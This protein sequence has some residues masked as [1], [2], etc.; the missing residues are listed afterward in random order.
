VGMLEEALAA[1]FW[2]ARASGRVVAHHEPRPRASP[3][4]GKP[5]K[6]TATS[7]KT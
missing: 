3:S 2:Y 5:R 7:T 1:K 6:A 4:H